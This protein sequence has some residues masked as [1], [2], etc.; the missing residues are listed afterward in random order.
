MENKSLLNNVVIKTT[1]LKFKFDLHK[2]Y[3]SG[4]MVEY[5]IPKFET[6]PVS[7]P[8]SDDFVILN[9]DDQYYYI[10]DYKYNKMFV[11]KFQKLSPS[12]LPT[13]SSHISL[14]SIEE[15]DATSKPF[16]IYLSSLDEINICSITKTNLVKYS[17]D[18]FKKDKIKKVLS[19]SLLRMYECYGNSMYYEEVEYTLFLIWNAVELVEAQQARYDAFVKGHNQLISLFESDDEDDEDDDDYE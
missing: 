12:C 10:L 9:N 18:Y 16:H 3:W 13:D 6:V 4:D 2:F 8:L 17:R 19:K 15:Y 5:S 1:T 11:L 14:S 7:L